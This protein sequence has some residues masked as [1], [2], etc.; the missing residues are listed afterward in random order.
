MRTFSPGQLSARARR[1]FRKMRESGMTAWVGGN[2]PQK[3]GNRSVRGI[4][5]LTRVTEGLSVHDFGCGIGR[6]SV[7][8]LEALGPGGRLTGTDIVPAMVGFCRDCIGAEYPNARFFRLAARNAHY[9]QFMGGADAVPEA[10][11]APVAEETFFGEHAGGFDLTIALSVFTHLPPQQMEKYFAYVRQTVAGQGAFVFSAFL[12]DEESV[13]ALGRA[14]C[15]IKVPRVPRLGDEVFYGLPTDKLGF[16][17]YRLSAVRRRLYAAGFYIESVVF[18]SWRG[19]RSP[20]DQDH[21]LAR[22]LA[23]RNSG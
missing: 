21:I 17:A 6:T 22:P 15:V 9:D 5:R 4:N 2:D 8:L 13:D 18:G 11:P 10:Q 7:P 19:R 3:A 23:E 14:D 1:V 12:I 16:V 20:V